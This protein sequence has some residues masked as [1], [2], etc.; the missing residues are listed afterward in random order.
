VPGDENSAYQHPEELLR[1]ADTAMYRA[2]ALGRNRHE[3]FDINMHARAI[4]EL[5]T[6]NELRRALGRD[7]FVLHYQPVCQSGGEIVGFEALLRWNHPVRG[8][9]SPDEFMEIAE[10]HGWLVSIGEWTLREACRQLCEWRQQKSN[11]LFISVN[12]SARQFAQLDL[13][14]VVRRILED[15]GLPPGC[16]QLEIAEKVL[17]HNL[18]SR[19]TL[20]RLKDT[21]V[22]LALDDFGT[23]FSSLLWLQLFGLDELKIDRSLVS[24]SS[25]DGLI[26]SELVST[27]VA[28]ARS[29]GAQAIAEGVENQAQWDEVR[30]LGCDGAQGYYFKKPMPP[31]EVVALLEVTTI[32]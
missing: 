10:G 13:P 9:L 21:G 31:G 26:N 25:P 14:V 28:L 29:L 23:G 22:R 17:M 27:M 4:A 5:R 24:D 15:T 1:D 19:E 32:A 11:E 16:L 3:V 30:A 2:K 18:A 7:E 6:E 12:L 20:R 8:L